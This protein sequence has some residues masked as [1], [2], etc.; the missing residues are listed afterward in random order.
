MI[1]I[2]IIVVGRLLGAVQPR[3]RHV[4]SVAVDAGRVVLLV[5]PAVTTCFVCRVLCVFLF[6]F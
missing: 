4:E 3:G 1:I 6:A 2:I 5:L